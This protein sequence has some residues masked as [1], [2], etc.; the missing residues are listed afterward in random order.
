MSAASQIGGRNWAARRLSVG[1]LLGWVCVVSTVCSGVFPAFCGMN[2]RTPSNCC[3]VSMI[4]L[5]N[6]PSCA[7]LSRVLDPQPAAIATG[8]RDHPACFRRWPEASTLEKK[9]LISAP[10]NGIA[11]LQPPSEQFDTV[12]R[13]AILIQIAYACFLWTNPRTKSPPELTI[14][15]GQ[16]K[17][18]DASHR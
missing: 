10:A 17:F 18:N 5:V 4:R 11:S 13:V 2:G 16:G 3:E 14:R 15:S 7:S 8:S 1:L 9:K 12:A 6:R